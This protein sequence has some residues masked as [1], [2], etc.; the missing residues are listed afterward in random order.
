MICS[1][2][3]VPVRSLPFLAVAL[4]LF[5]GSLQATPQQDPDLG[6]QVRELFA[7]KCLECHHPESESKKARRDFDGA[8]DLA[9][10]VEAWSDPIAIDLAPLWEVGQERSMPPEDAKLPRL[11]GEEANLLL[12]WLEAG[13]P[14]PAD[15]N[16]FVDLAM[17]A[18]YL[19][20]GSLLPRRDP[21]P[22]AAP[23][24]FQQRLQRWLGR[25]HSAL[26]HF[27]VALILLAAWMRLWSWGPWRE[28][29][30]RA[31]R[32]CLLYAAPTA[33]LSAALGWLLAYDAGMS[34]ALLERHRWVGTGVA[35]VTLGLLFLRRPFASRRSYGILLLLLALATAIAG[36]QGGELVFGEEYLEF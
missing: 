32:F 2:S 36:H 24:S 34:S 30:Q 1:R 17:A 31:E 3:T 22:E 4:Y 20:E 19:P 7:R 18:R 14:M 11:T 8:W 28:R 5:A 25:H 12:A 15:G 10:V 33:V 29:A 16:R 26:V 13:T 35:L 9:L 6:A 21:D 27:P 23:A